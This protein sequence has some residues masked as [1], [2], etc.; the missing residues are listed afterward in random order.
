MNEVKAFFG[1]ELCKQDLFIIDLLISYN[2]WEQVDEALASL[3]NLGF[4]GIIEE[5]EVDFLKLH[6]LPFEA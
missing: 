1:G 6:T 3:Y 4:C 2:F 5:N